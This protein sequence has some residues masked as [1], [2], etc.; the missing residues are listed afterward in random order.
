MR[1]HFTRTSSNA[2]TGPIPTV[3]ISSDSCPPDCPLNDGGCYAKSG[4]SGMHWAKV[5]RGERGGSFKEL[6]EKI[7]E[8]P[9]RQ[10]WRYAVAGDLPGKGNRIARSL[11]RQLVEVNRGRSGFTYTHKPPHK[12]GNVEAIREANDKKFTINLSSNN[13]NHADEYRKN[14]PDLPVV[15]ILPEDMGE[16]VTMMKNGV[17]KKTRIWKKTYTPENNLVVQCP[18]EYNP[19]VQCENCGGGSPL[20]VRSDRQFIVGF[21]PHGTG[22][23]KA[24]RIARLPVVE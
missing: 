18:A 1:F 19:K 10:V 17:E 12:Y 13:L 3:V 5:N 2:K 21:T 24:G 15:T 9:Y 11:L 20:C 7:R 8:L 14:Y 6:L 4:P 23:R 22:K 16:P